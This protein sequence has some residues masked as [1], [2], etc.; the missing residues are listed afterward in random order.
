MQS[1]GVSGWKVA[2]ATHVP[3]LPCIVWALLCTLGSAAL[4]VSGD[5]GEGDGA[6]TLDLVSG[7]RLSCWR[8]AGNAYAK[9]RTFGVARPSACIKCAFS[10]PCCPSLRMC[11]RARGSSPRDRGAGP[12]RCRMMHSYWQPSRTQMSAMSSCCQAFAL[13]PPGTELNSLSRGP[14]TSS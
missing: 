9:K 4:S 10:Q 7:A 6:L 12:L 14:Q 8:A 5:G 2:T 3:M 1:G 11:R 13:G